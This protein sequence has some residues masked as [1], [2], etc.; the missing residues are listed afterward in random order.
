MTIATL[1]VDVAANVSK[2]Q[3]DVA[4]VHT[5]LD[6]IGTAAGKVG[7][8]LAGAFTVTAVAGA[9]SKVLDYAGK[10][11][12]LA[13]QTGLSTRAIQ[14]M[15][16]AAKMTGASLENFTGAAFKLGTNLA[17]GSSSV[18][19]AVEKLGLSYM[20]LRRMSPDE[21]FNTI[22]TALGKVENAQD[23]NKLAVD[24]FSKSAQQILPAIAEGYEDLASAANVAGDEQLQALDMAGQALDSFWE[25]LLSVGTQ[26]AGGF[27][28]AVREALR[29]FND[30]VPIV[31]NIK[32]GM[33]A[34]S[35]VLE[36][37]GFKSVEVPKVLN[38]AAVA[39]KNLPA[40]IRAV[41]QSLE[42][43]ERWIKAN[44]IAVDASIE[45]HKAWTQSAEDAKYVGVIWGE[46]LSDFDHLMADHNITIGDF[47]T[48]QDLAAR[49]AA[50]T[51]DQLERLGGTVMVIGPLLQNSMTLPWT[52]FA[53]TVKAESPKFVRSFDA[54]G[55]AVRNMGNTI[56]SAVQGGGSVVKALGSSFGQ[57]IGTDFVTNFGAKIEGALGKT[58]GGAFNAV[59]PGVGALLGPLLGSIGNK[60]K[61]LFGIGISAEAKAAAEAVKAANAQL[62]VDLQAQI[63]GF[64]SDIDGL[65]GKGADLGYT[66]N[67]A[68]DVIGIKFDKMREIAGKYGTD[69]ASLGTKFQ[70]NRLHEAAQT[71][72]DDFWLLVHGG[73]DVGAVLLGMS[74]Q[75][76]NLVNDSIKFG[77]KIPENMKPWIQNLL[78]AGKLTDENG[79]K[80]KD[81]T[82]IQFGDPVAAQYLTIQSAII[83]LIAK[84]D[85]LITR[86]SA[87][88]SN[89]TL[90]LTTVHENVYTGGD[91]GDERPGFA[92]GSGGIRDFG[93]GTL[94]VLHGRERVQTERQMQVEQAGSGGSD[95]AA[96]DQINRLIRDLPRAMKVAVSDAMVLQGARR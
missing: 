2:L 21:Q 45:S 56:L 54:I 9:A 91:G 65:I 62:I 71:I 28:I 69:L 15:S 38:A 77:T 67:Q 16:H 96:L 13:G 32:D 86:I 3:T 93:N 40:P 29:V 82:G 18:Q 50:D 31:R 85:D 57:A 19:G 37:F 36:T 63:T 55:S 61:G 34:W 66:F 68:G 24:L 4:K 84:I 30:W 26:L 74:P 64:K 90:T 41:S 92:S 12:D 87:I 8:M 48:A 53:E 75:I 88:P 52:R 70:E 76:N 1:I 60:L 6:G 95:G 43:Q 72:I 17:G 10:I 20:D 35:T 49:A 44:T 23:R 33:E 42:E 11:N 39:A 14:Q 59:I 83:D 94:A 58:L 25:S 81:L 5:Q 78:D 27:I 80:M 51:N 79:V 46:G 7:A 47:V 22:A 89:K 73:A